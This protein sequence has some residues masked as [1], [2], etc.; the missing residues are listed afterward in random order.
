M[1]WDAVD[2]IIIREE[3]EG[4]L[5]EL[6]IQLAK[7]WVV[8]MAEAQGGSSDVFETSNLL[9]MAP[10]P[11]EQQQ[12]LAEY[13]EQALETVLS[14]LGRAAE[15]EKWGKLVV[16]IF[17]DPHSYSGYVA[18]FYP[19]DSVIP[20]SGGICLNDGYTHLALYNEQFEGLLSMY[21]HEVTH[22]YLGHQVLPVWMDEAIAMRM[23]S[24][25]A[26][27]EETYLDRE[28]FDRHRRLW[29][30]ETLEQFKSGESWRISGDSFTLSYH[31]A[32]ILWK[33]IET[34]LEARP[35]EIQ[36][37]IEKS[38]YEDGGDA[39]LQE[40]FGVTLNDLIKSFLGDVF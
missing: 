24:L 37:L 35:E 6:F 38:S 1:D 39:A 14:Y 23:E 33:K 11:G 27:R 20:M 16:F 8:K 15:S 40:V 25:V 31:L 34:N 32:E 29:N 36:D 13:L 22:A 26:G 9:V 30:R 21:V 4:N 7:E 18:Q 3:Y 19:E 2:E 10:H 17:D 12:E 28:L 5:G